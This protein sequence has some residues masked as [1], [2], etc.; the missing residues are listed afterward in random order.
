MT[1]R[2]VVLHVADLGLSLE[3]YRKHLSAELVVSDSAHA[4]LDFVTATIELRHLAEGVPSGWQEDDAYEG[5]RHIGFKMAGLDAIIAS[6][7]AEGVT[8]RSRPQELDDVGIRIAFFF[9]PDGTVLELVERHLSYH[10]VRSEEGVA[11]ER[12]M[13]PPSRPRFD[14]I[15]HSVA[16]LPAAVDRYRSAGFYNIGALQWPELHLEFLRAEGTV[17]ELFRVPGPSIPS[18]LSVDSFGFVGV[19]LDPPVDG[20]VAVGMLG[21]GRLLAGDADGLGIVMDDKSAEAI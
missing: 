16:D 14:H 3:F 2:N 10:V 12:R 13:P 17:I 9:D 19:Q 15:A 5:S 11:D 4:V 21:D 8:F 18:S 7:D 6:L 1:V 20:L